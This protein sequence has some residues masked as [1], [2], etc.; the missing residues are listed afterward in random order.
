[1]VDSGPRRPGTDSLTQTST[2]NNVCGCLSVL[3]KL[4]GAEHHA[5]SS[6]RRERSYAPMNL[7][8]FQ[9]L[10]ARAILLPLVLA[11]LLGVALFWTVRSLNSAAAWVDHTDEV[12]GQ[13]NYLLKLIVDMETSL[14]GY[15]ITGDDAFLQP[16]QQATPLVPQQ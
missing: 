3:A 12:I 5:D 6:S 14:R 10:L 8:K 16:Y 11:I 13:S 2:V 4:L 7:Q 1:L 9:A 15:V